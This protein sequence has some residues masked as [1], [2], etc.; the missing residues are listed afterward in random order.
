MFW[1]GFLAFPALAAAVPQGYGGSGSAMLRFGCSQVVIERLDPLVNPGVNPSPHVHQV[2]GG[3]AFG[4]S[5]PE[6]DI[7]THSTCTTCSFNQDFSNYWTAN[8]YFKARNGTYKRVPQIPNQAVSGNNGGITVYYTSPGAKQTT[9][10]KPGFRM[11]TGESTRR[12]STG[13]GKNMQS[14]FRCYTGPNFEGN[15][16]SP[17]FDPKLDTEYFPTGPCLGG[18]RTNII[19]PLCWDG[20]NLDSPNHMDHVAHPTGGPTSFA[21]VSGTCPSTHPVKIPQVH[22]EIMWDTT[23]FNNKAEWP[24]DGSQPFVLSTGDS[25]GYGQHADYVFGWKDDTLQQ[26]M[27]NACFGATCRS[28]TTQSDSVSGSC[29]VKNTVAE[30]T[31]GWLKELP[32]GGMGA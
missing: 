15:V 14:C 8:L 29:A 5:M 10:F 11:L 13:L 26:A 3:N 12:N 19:F 32:G 23:A 1:S 6:D 31:E 17:C 7:S 24:E 21:A 25:T 28:L 20:K 2:V 30:T 27:D 16:Y 18:I 4:A 22:L 9:A